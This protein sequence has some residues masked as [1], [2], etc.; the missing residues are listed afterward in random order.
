SETPVQ[1]THVQ[2]VLIAVLYDAAQIVGGIMNATAWSD[3]AIEINS[4]LTLLEEHPNIVVREDVV[5]GEVPSWQQPLDGP[6]RIRGSIIAYLDR[7]ED[8][9]TRALQQTDPHSADYLD[10]LRSHPILYALVVRCI[11][12][13]ER[14]G[15]T[16]SLTRAILTRL[17][18]VYY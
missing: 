18:Q 4:L 9:F 13:F 3:A 1:R 7:L 5:E 8:E 12:Y 17:E 15:H 6:V 2:L 11:A 14:I 10:R 16:S